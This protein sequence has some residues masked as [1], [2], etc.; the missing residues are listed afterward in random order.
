MKNSEIIGNRY[1][2][3]D[4][5]YFT[6]VKK[7]NEDE[8]IIKNTRFWILWWRIGLFKIMKYL[9]NE[10]YFKC[11]YPTFEQSLLVLGFTYV[12]QEIKIILKYYLFYIILLKKIY[13]TIFK[14]YL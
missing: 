14:L 5:N 6:L 4:N 11:N 2:N 10:K 1:Y 9:I 12:F 8:Y 3:K 7:D 13:Q